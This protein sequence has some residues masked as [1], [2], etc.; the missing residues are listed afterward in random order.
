MATNPDLQIDLMALADVGGH[1]AKVAFELHRQLREQYGAV[2]C[3]VPLEGIALAVGIVEIVDHPTEAFEGSLLANGNTG[4][5]VLRKGMPSGRRRFTLGH[6]LFHFLSPWHRSNSQKFECSGADM[7]RQRD[8]SS[9]WDNVSVG[10]KMEIEANEFSNA[11]LLPGP[12]YKVARKQMGAIPSLAQI[13]SL[14]AKFDV[15]TPVMCQ[16]YVKTSREMLAVVISQNGRV[17][18]VIPNAGFPY[19]GL[20]KG[21]PLP[22]DSLTVEF[23]KSRQSRKMS[24]VLE[25]SHTGWLDSGNNVSEL[26]EQTMLQ[27]NGF[28]V[29]LLRAELKEDDQDDDDRN[30][31]RRSSSRFR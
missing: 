10:E 18:Q 6:E 11:L 12:E 26:W 25:V 8:R 21:S 7:R 5:I 9:S 30:W 2:P 13:E 15:S 19:L 23:S 17:T 3:S 20:R 14:K 31:N 4:A 27:G 29:T 28:A 1:P 24:D 16:T 22:H